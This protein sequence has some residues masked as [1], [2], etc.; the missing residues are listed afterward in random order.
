VSLCL[1]DAQVHLED[2]LKESEDMKEQLA[3]S[4]RR[5]NLMQAEVEET[6]AAMEQIERSRKVVEQELL[7]TT[8]RA[9]LLHS[10][11]WLSS[12]LP[13]PRL[14]MILVSLSHVLLVSPCL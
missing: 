14:M 9:Q 10:Q 4:E 1:Q 6:R 11:V 12:P 8:E 5:S 7:D 13:H 3:M 2:S